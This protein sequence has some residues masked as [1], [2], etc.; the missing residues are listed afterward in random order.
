M[1]QQ[2]LQ[3]DQMQPQAPAMIKPTQPSALPIP[4]PPASYIIPPANNGYNPPA[5]ITS[6]PAQANLA[7]QTSIAPIQHIQGSGGAT[8]GSSGSAEPPAATTVT[9]PTN[10]IHFT[11]TVTSGAFSSHSQPLKK[12]PVT[13]NASISTS[14]TSSTFPHSSEE[15]QTHHAHV[16]DERVIEISPSG[17]Y[18]KLNTILGKGAY[19]V[20]WKAL[21]L[22]EGLEVAWNAFQTTKQESTELSQEIEILKKVR[23]PN[24]IS[25]RDSWFSNG[26]FVF[27]TELMTSGTLR[28]YIQKLKKPPV[29]VVRRWARQILKGLSY[30][31]GHRPPIIHRDIKCDNLFIN[32][33]HCEIK[34]GDMG[35]AKMKFGK[36]Y[37]VIGTPEFMAP[38]MYEE[39]GYNEKVDVY[40]FGMCLLEMVT[41]EYP[42]SECKNAAQIYKKVSNGVRPECL[43]RV[44]DEEIL[45][46]I[47][48]CIAPE[49]ERP[50]VKQVLE[51]PFFLSDP[52]VVLLSSD[53]MRGVLLMQV[54][55]QGVDRLSVKFEFNIDSDTAED[56][57]SEMIEERVLH[58][59]YRTHV[60]TDINNILRDVDRYSQSLVSEGDGSDPGVASNI[61]INA[62]PTAATTPMSTTTIEEPHAHHRT[63][64]EERSVAPEGFSWR[65]G[66]SH[67][68][69]STGGS[70]GYR[71]E[72]MRAQKEIEEAKE[73]MR[74]AEKRAK[75]MELK[76][77]Q[78][79][80]RKRELDLLIGMLRKELLIKGG[81][82][83]HIGDAG[84]MH[85]PSPSVAASFGAA[86]SDRIMTPPPVA[87]S[88]ILS[89]SLPQPLL[90]AKQ[91]QPLLV[92]NVLGSPVY[93][94][95]MDAVANPNANPE[96]IVSGATSV[97]L[98][99]NS[100]SAALTGA[101]TGL[102]GED[103]V[104]TMAIPTHP[105]YT[106]M[107][108]D[109]LVS[110]IAH[111]T[112]RPEKASEW[113]AKLRSQDIKTVGDLCELHEEDWPSMNLTVFA[114]RALRNA[115]ITRPVLKSKQPAVHGSSSSTSP[116]GKTTPPPSTMVQDRDRDVE[117]SRAS[118]SA[119]SAGADADVTERILSVNNDDFTMTHTR[120]P[121]PQS[122][123]SSSTPRRSASPQLQSQRRS[124]LEYTNETNYE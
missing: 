26:E 90:Q 78:E 95:S 3:Q 33:A 6:P 12:T 97:A 47:L 42:Y 57:V 85:H 122:P 101:H 32:G 111:S 46:L 45:S 99:P 7:P 102:A 29:P 51:H 13:T 24:I 37:T 4:I 20:V 56:V 77:L 60:T 103:A 39:K 75:E 34:I 119:F 44:Q 21:D 25:F 87:P 52:E 117:S 2:H 86:V 104:A 100:T 118:A 112:N 91:P 5:H 8:P 69:A 109:D 66:D 65:R 31:H 14:I 113:I 9:S 84:M 18:G 1:Q 23:H 94:S 16:D 50:S 40:A 98:S 11:K 28:E 115:I 71:A 19:K 114:S 68:I 27:I 70:P 38:E 64:V 108:I 79:E 53:S 58:E 15:I 105:L 121:P 48:A 120:S 81:A 35:T 74:E 123:S 55:F 83:D 92:P 22:E 67:I 88:S 49:H 30:L 89:S 59:R 96:L 80:E 62:V 76:A 43:Q 110:E 82:S 124:N 61:N 54:V 36:K 93:S 41:G 107:P 72:W 10:T 73:R 63:P 106:D 17:R 116:T